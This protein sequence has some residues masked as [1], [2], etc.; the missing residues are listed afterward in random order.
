[1]CCDKEI[2]TVEATFMN[3][4]KLCI[5]VKIAFPQ[6]MVGQ[7]LIAIWRVEKFNSLDKTPWGWRWRT[8]KRVGL[9]IK[10]CNLVYEKWR[11]KCW[12]DEDW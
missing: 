11:I 7:V 6:Y 8:P 10:Q 12:F 1:M 3:F 2:L 5:G 9:L 4:S